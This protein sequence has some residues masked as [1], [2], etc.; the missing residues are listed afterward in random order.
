MKIYDYQD[1][2][3]YQKA[4]EFQQSIF[5]VSQQFPKEELFSLTDQIRRSSR[6]VGACIAGAWEKRRY[7]NHFRSKLSDALSEHAETKHWLCTA[8][9]CEYVDVGTYSDLESSHGELR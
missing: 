6:S 4:F 9:A 8:R 5:H 3:V 1:S 7:V 2:E